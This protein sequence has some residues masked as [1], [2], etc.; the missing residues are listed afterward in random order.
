MSSPSLC[1]IPGATVTARELK[2]PEYSMKGHLQNT[3]R[4]SNI[5]FYALNRCRARVHADQAS[6][7]E[8]A[9]EMQ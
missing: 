1:K 4:I 5:F 8:I 6:E 7:R 3:D 9:Q 2:C